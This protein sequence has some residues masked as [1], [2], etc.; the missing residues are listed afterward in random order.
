[1]QREGSL[2]IDF[3][4]CLHR[5]VEMVNVVNPKALVTREGMKLKFLLIDPV[6]LKR[7]GKGSGLMS[8]KK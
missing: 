2:V 3:R 5:F 4:R 1:M 6:F 8:R 7:Q